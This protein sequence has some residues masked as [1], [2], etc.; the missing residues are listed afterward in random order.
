MSKLSELDAALTELSAHSKGILEA[1]QGIRGLLSGE[2]S[3]R[4]PAVK[5]FT[6]SDVRSRLTELARIGHREAVQA[7]LRRHG[8][9]MLKNIDP[10]EYA[11]IME[12]AEAIGK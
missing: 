2:E 6:L 9:D 8:A 7:L 5:E 4:P 1:V 11:A 10:G 12:E 3:P